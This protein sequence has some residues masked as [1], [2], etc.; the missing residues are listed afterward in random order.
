MAL[1]GRAASV[2]R[3][4]EGDDAGDM[5]IPEPKCDEKRT[6]LSSLDECDFPPNSLGALMAEV[7]MPP[8]V[9]SAWGELVGFGPDYAEFGLQP[10]MALIDFPMDAYT[11][12]VKVK[13]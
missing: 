3:G 1:F 5:S 10:F 13:K 11:D 7:K 12:E 8:A 9:A 2:A 6:T 4:S